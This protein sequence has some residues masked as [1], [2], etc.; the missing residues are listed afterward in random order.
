[1]CHLLLSHFFHICLIIHQLHRFIFST[2][3]S[4]KL[5]GLPAL[6]PARIIINARSEMSKWRV[7]LWFHESNK[8]VDIKE[9]EEGFGL[10]VHWE[11]LVHVSRLTGLKSP[12]PSGWL[13]VC[14]DAHGGTQE[15]ITPSRSQCVTLS[16][17]RK[18]CMIL[19]V[20][21]YD[22]LYCSRLDWA[23]AVVL[24]DAWAQA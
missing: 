24:I 16:S 23:V 6:S 9:P 14:Q 12:E 21:L 2:M 15:N 1:M 8:S 10:S 19:S 18:L 3:V 22:S 13:R 11:T 20:W 17:Y 7:S 5:T 4:D